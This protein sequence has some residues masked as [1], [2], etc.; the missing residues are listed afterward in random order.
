M[1]IS[2]ASSLTV[3]ADVQCLTY[4]ANLHSP[5]HYNK[6]AQ[7]QWKLCACSTKQQNTLKGKKSHSLF[8]KKAI[9]MANQPYISNLLDVTFFFLA[10]QNNW[11]LGL[12]P[13]TNWIKTNNNI[14]DVNV[15]HR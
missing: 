3:K 5:V 15:F 4:N 2:T 10:F 14:S 11:I 7:N 8:F 12:F 6:G 9:M 1:L 13:N